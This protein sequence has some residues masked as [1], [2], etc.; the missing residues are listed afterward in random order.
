[1]SPDARID[2]KESV[3]LAFLAALQ[4]LPPKQR[5]VLLLRDVLGWQTAECAALLETTDPAIESALQRARETVSKKSGSLRT[6]PKPADDAT[7][8]ALLGKYVQ[9]WEQADPNVL[10]SLLRED[11]TLSMP[12]YPEWLSGAV[13]IGASIQEMVF[14]PAGPGAFRL[15]A[16][17]VNGQPAFLAY[18][19]DPATGKLVPFAIHVLSLEGD[20]IAA[21]DAFHDTSLFATL[22]LPLAP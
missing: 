19:P 4:L 12:P 15:V 5:A 22:G 18:S 20:R 7:T 2:E 6:A 8:K 17:R 14:G 10:V 21:I 11:A 1:M 16:A 3:A 9:A 13:T